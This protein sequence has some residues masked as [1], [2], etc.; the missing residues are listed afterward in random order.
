MPLPPKIVAA[1]IEYDDQSYVEITPNPKRK[2]K[3]QYG[4][5][6]KNHNRIAYNDYSSG[7]W[8]AMMAVAIMAQVPE[9]KE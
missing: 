2:G 1:T 7:V 8:A 5:Y 3:F 4:Y 6:D 9:K